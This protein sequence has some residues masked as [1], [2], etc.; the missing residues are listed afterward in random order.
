[1]AAQTQRPADRREGSSQQRVPELADVVV[2][3]SGFAGLAAAIEARTAGASVVVLEKMRVPGGNSVISDGGIAAPETDYQ[4]RVGIEDSVELMYSDIMTAGGHLSC[5]ELVRVVA[6]GA[7]EAFLWTRDDLGVEYLNRVDIFGGHSVPRCYTPPGISGLSLVRK[8]LQRLRLLGGAVCRGVLVRG[9]TR[10]HDGPID[11]V[12]VYLDHDRNRPLGTPMR[13]AARRAVVVASGGFGSDTAFRQSLDDRFGSQLQS[14]NK[15]LATAEVL[16]NCLE[17]GANAV[18]LSRIQLGPWA[19]PDERGFGVGPLFGDYVV[20][21]Y[22]ML[23]DIRTGSRFV[24]ELQDRQTVAEAILSRGQPVLGVADRRAVELAGWDLTAALERG[25]VRTFET[26]AELASFYGVQVE[27][28]ER[29]AARYNHGVCSGRDLDFDKQFPQG[30]AALELPPYYAMRV[31]PK[32]HYT[33]GG[34]QI[35]T[36]AR[37]IHRDGYPIAGL[38]AA[39]EVTGGI[40]GASRLGSCAIT[41]CLVMGRIAGREAAGRGE[42]EG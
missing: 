41:D 3:G 22:G 7:R 34:L 2:V 28:L 10:M 23:V 35:D 15:P 5:P 4:L 32:V 16:R 26:W 9:L 14:T 37:V 31:W 6:S 11:G 18:D 29:T 13:V 19:S 17:L 27:D 36:R 33:M 42:Q 40:H 1:M 39:G 38:L 25:V 20:L 30:A 21:P 12:E 8:L 24:N